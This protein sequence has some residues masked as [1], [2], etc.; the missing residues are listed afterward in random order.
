MAKLG[1]L[2]A[3]AR[4]VVAGADFRNIH[5]L[6]QGYRLRI[7]C[8]STTKPGQRTLQRS[9]GEIRNDFDVGSPRTNGFT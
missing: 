4:D 1:H 3:G 7:P 2:E 9:S 8:G 5:P 6:V